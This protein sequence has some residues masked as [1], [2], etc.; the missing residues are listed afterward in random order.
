[1]AVREIHAEST[2]T[3]F[4]T[5]NLSYGYDA[6][7]NIT[8][9][10]DNYQS[11]RSQTLGY[12]NLNRLNSASGAY[13]SLS[14]TYDGVGNRATSVT[15]GTTNTYNYGS[16]SNQLNSISVSGST[17]RSFSYAN[18]GQVSQ[19]VR[20]GSSTYGFTY[21]ND[22]RISSASLNGSTVG[23]YLYNGVEQRVAKTVSSTTTHDVYD[24]FGHLMSED[25]GSG[26]PIREYIWLGNMPI[27]LVDHG[28]MSPATYY[29]HT[30]QLGRPQKMTDG[31]ASLVWD[32][33]YD[34]FGNVSSVS[35]TATNLLMFPGQLYDSE[36]ALA[37]N[38]NREYDSTLGRYIQSDRIGLGGGINSYSYADANPT[39][40]LDPNGNTPIGA[41]I[42]GMIGELVLENRTGC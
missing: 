24:R 30:D 4:P 14:F 13:G 41:I 37:Q 8:G 17:V 40:I 6:A 11:A 18:S 23:S 3:P 38:W 22:G 10:T 35:G 16:S 7:G 20:G 32:A 2:L 27:A 36:T 12:D 9:I 31:S 34:P 33:I 1:L 15:G 39:R 5:Q 26:N 21:N 42:G 19:D 28:G 29:V 25:D